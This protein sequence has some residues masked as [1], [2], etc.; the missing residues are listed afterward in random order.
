MDKSPTHS[1]ND[2]PSP[3]SDTHVSGPRS[4]TIAAIANIA[5]LPSSPHISRPS[6]SMVTSRDAQDEQLRPLQ[7]FTTNISNQADVH[8]DRTFNVGKVNPTQQSRTTPPAG[9]GPVRK[10]AH[11]K[12]DDA[13]HSI[14]A[15]LPKAVQPSITVTSHLPEYSNSESHSKDHDIHQSNH[16]RTMPV[17]MEHVPDRQSVTDEQLIDARASSTLFLQS[18][19]AEGMN[20]ELTQQYR[21]AASIPATGCTDNIMDERIKMATTEKSAYTT[22]ASTPS[23]T[24]QQSSNAENVASTTDSTKAQGPGGRFWTPGEHRLVVDS[25]LKNESWEIIA[26]KLPGRTAED[27]RRYIEEPRLREQPGTGSHPHWTAEEERIVF[28]LKSQRKTWHEIAEVLP[29]RSGNGCRVRWMDKFSQKKEKKR[30]WWEIAHEARMELVRDRS[31]N[32]QRSARPRGTV[33]SSVE[34]VPHRKDREE[35]EENSQRRASTF[36]TALHDHNRGSTVK[37]FPHRSPTRATEGRDAQGPCYQSP[38]EGSFNARYVTQTPF[39]PPPWSPAH[40]D[41]GFD[42]SSY[43]IQVSE[44]VPYP[45]QETGREQQSMNQV[46]SLHSRRDLSGASTTSPHLYELPRP[47]NDRVFKQ[48]DS[49][50]ADD[51]DVDMSPSRYDIGSHQRQRMLSIQSLCTPDGDSVTSDYWRPGR[52]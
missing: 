4:Y 10:I 6:T 24:T 17:L 44:I 2:V 18:G 36:Q 51:A 28:E 26:Q 16:Q 43:G 50:L 1:S 25:R 42:P 20:P 8:L 13:H 14:T 31:G 19:S 30:R 9:S 32:E 47:H 35:A 41:Y 21:K 5:G 12:E 34:R 11:S 49:N 52:G 22:T 48:R 45:Y 29:A 7:N 23:S 38:R 40:V 3:S 33:R 15:L 37:S 27:C 39:I 46:T